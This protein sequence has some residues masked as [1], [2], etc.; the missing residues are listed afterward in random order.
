MY[1]DQ[2]AEKNQFISPLKIPSFGLIKKKKK[3]SNCFRKKQCFGKQTKKIEYL[4]EE[5]LT[6]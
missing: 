3:G 5:R 6:A 2:L 1:K 4:G